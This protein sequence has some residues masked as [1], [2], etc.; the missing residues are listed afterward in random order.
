MK[1]Y[2]KSEFQFN[3]LKALLLKKKRKS[4]GLN[5]TEFAPMLGK[6]R[7]VIANYETLRTPISD[8]ILNKMSQF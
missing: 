2:Y 8:E 4:L 6:T 1:S 7:N 3:L 5:Q